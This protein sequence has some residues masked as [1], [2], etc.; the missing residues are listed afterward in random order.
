M[1]SIRWAAF[2][3]IAGTYVPRKGAKTSVQEGA[4]PWLAGAHCQHKSIPSLEISSFRS[5]V[6]DLLVW[7]SGLDSDE[8]SVSGHVLSMGCNTFHI[9][10]LEQPYDFS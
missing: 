9:A 7:Q 2:R 3:R 4:L 5:L 1:T 6:S 8:K 10:T